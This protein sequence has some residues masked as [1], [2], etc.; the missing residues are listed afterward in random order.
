[1]GFWCVL[2]VFGDQATET[3]VTSLKAHPVRCAWGFYPCWGGHI[4]WEFQFS[5]SQDFSQSSFSWLGTPSL[6]C[7]HGLVQPVAV[8]VTQRYLDTKLMTIICPLQTTPPQSPSVLCYSTK[9]A[10]VWRRKTCPRKKFWTQTGISQ[11]QAPETSQVLGPA[12]HSYLH[13]ECV[14]D[15]GPK[16]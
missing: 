2:G 9:E 15:K 11:S 1:M 7:S 6:A 8:R 13:K 10:W 4:P 12:H 5:S 3:L 16:F 14:T